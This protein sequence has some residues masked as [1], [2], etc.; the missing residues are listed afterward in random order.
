MNDEK[1]TSGGDQRSEAE[2]IAEKN[3]GQQQQQQG[4]TKQQGAGDGRTDEEII[5]EKLAGQGGSK[6]E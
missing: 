1:D 3:A 2:I 4:E 6:S 5:A